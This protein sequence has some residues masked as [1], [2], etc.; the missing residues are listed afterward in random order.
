MAY[1]R[2]S[3]K[4]E[5][6]AALSSRFAGAV[7]ELKKPSFVPTGLQEDIIYAVGCGKYQIVVAIDANRVGKTTTLVNIG[8]NIIWPEFVDEYF[9][10]W[11]GENFFRQWPFSTKRFRLTGTP[12]NL[13]DNGALQQ[14]IDLWWPSGRY[15]KDKAGKHH[16]CSFETDSGWGGDALTYE[17][18]SQEY[19]GQTLSLVISDE[20]PKADLI[21]AINSR[22]AEGGVWVI[23]MTPINCGVFLD[24][25]DDLQRSGKRV[26]V[27]SG[28]VYENDIDTGKPN[29]NGTRKGLWTKEQIDD[30]IA[31]IPIDERESRVYGRASHKSGKVFP[32]YDDTVHVLTKEEFDPTSGILAK[33]NCYMGIDPHRAYWPAIVWVAVTPDGRHVVYNEFPTVE[34]F[35]GNF[36]DEVRQVRKFNKTFEE[37]ADFIKAYDYEHHGAKILKRAPDPRFSLQCPDFIDQLGVFG[38]KNWEMPTLEFRGKGIAKLQEGFDWNEKLP[39]TSFN[40]PKMYVLEHCHNV[41]RSLSRHYWEERVIKRTNDG[42]EAED[43]KDF[44]DALLYISSVAPDEYYEP[45]ENHEMVIQGPDPMQDLRNTFMPNNNQIYVSVE[46]SIHA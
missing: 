42:K 25:L 29:H 36:Y 31:G 5:F 3:V 40:Q 33:C 37:L 12:T 2:K 46:R 35:G 18:S 23:G 9:D 45:Y 38:I 11:Q 32:Q 44:V 16:F 10:F 17:Q 34:Y 27:L 19:E 13:A 22:M 41:R 6:R 28:S 26:H 14:A 21:G 30:F 8:K 20:P 43:Y 4:D 24:V 39:R 1:N 15:R 7:R